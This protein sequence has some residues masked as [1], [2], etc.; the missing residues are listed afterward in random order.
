[1]VQAHLSEL[2]GTWQ[3]TGYRK[4]EH[5]MCNELLRVFSVGVVG[6]F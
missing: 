2:N 3:I 5:S 1:M 4:A 6:T